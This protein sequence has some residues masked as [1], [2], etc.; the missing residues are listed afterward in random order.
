[1]SDGGMSDVKV[2]GF[3][4]LHLRKDGVDLPNIRLGDLLQSDIDDR[5]SRGPVRLILSQVGAPLLWIRS[6]DCSIA[7]NQRTGIRSKTI[8][9][10]GQTADRSMS[11]GYFFYASE[12]EPLDGVTLILLETVLWSRSPLN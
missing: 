9:F 11:P 7:W 4:I 2:K 5:F 3:P 1:M 12:W 6:E 8:S 10:F